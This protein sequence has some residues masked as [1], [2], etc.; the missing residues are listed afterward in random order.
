MLS[1]T[2]HLTT[3]IAPVPLLWVLP[4]GLYLLT[5]I[6]VFST[7]TLIPRRLLVRAWPML[8]LP[9]VITIIAQN[10]QPIWLLASLHLVAFFV[11][12]MLCHG[13][14]ADD[15]PAADRLTEF[16]LWLSVGGVLGGI[17]TAL[18]APVLFS[19]VLEYP[20][21][22]V[23][24]CVL[25]RPLPSELLRPSRCRLDFALPLGLGLLV[26]LLLLGAR[27]A[28]LP[29]GPLSVGTALGLPAVI[30]LSFSRRPIRFG[31]GIGAMLLVGTV[32]TSVQGGMLHVERSFFGI[33]RVALDSTGK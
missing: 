21:V 11:A 14:L 30:C 19:T 24:L 22:L 25:Q 13:A 7:K 2:T 28:G 29:P 33:N 3:E 26:A 1:V 31:L 4:L 15:R 12:A 10:T 6:L 23:L 9:L 18:L 32:Y 27:T 8:L 16:Y 5:F 20:I 17:F